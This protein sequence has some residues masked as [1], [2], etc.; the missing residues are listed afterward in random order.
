MFSRAIVTTASRIA[1]Y[2]LLGCTWFD[3]N[4]AVTCS[5]ASTPMTFGIYDPISTVQI[6]TTATV[7]ITCF[8]SL[9]NNPNAAFPVSATIS[10]GSAGGTYLTTRKMPGPIDTLNYQVYSDTIN[11][12]WQD[13]GGVAT[14]LNIPNRKNVNATSTLT[15]Y[16]TIPALQNVGVGS[17]LDNLVVTISY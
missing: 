5:V 14:T 8:E 4:A 17:Y 2:A 9:N 15:A 12:V 10:Q 7:T 6:T 16:G 3:A 13:I 11:T 1:L